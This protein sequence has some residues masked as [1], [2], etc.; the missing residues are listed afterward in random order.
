MSLSSRD[1]SAVHREVVESQSVA[2]ANESQCYAEPNVPH[3]RSLHLAQGGLTNAYEFCRRSLRKAVRNAPPVHLLANGHTAS[4][5][6]S[7][8]SRY[9]PQ[10]GDSLNPRASCESDSFRY[11]GN[12][13]TRRIKTP[14]KHSSKPPSRTRRSSGS[15]ALAKPPAEIVAAYDSERTR[16]RN[17]ISD[18]QMRSVQRFIRTWVAKHCPTH[19]D[20]RPWSQ[21]EIADA[22]GITQNEYSSWLN[23]RARP[24]LPRLVKLRE[25]TGTP[26]D[27]ILGLA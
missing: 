8:S 3:V 1:G 21:R 4:T 26:I 24:G 12:M 16:G 2:S 20:G 19:P 9:S 6:E 15:G 17:S 5:A 13:P 22:L 7:D 14:A 10:Q 11:T 18:E 25:S 23:D 27:V